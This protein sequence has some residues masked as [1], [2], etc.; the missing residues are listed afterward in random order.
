MYGGFRQEENNTYKTI[1]PGLSSL[2]VG[3]HDSLLDFPK[4]LKIF[5]QTGICGVIWQ[6]S[7]KY[8]GV[9]RVLLGGM[10]P[11]SSNAHVQCNAIRKKKKKNNNNNRLKSEII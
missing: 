1:P 11:Q 3:N 10:H 6:T 8:L 9:G 4:H 5:P 2:S 7:D